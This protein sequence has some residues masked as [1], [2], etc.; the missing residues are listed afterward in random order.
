MNTH[1]EVEKWEREL[2]NLSLDDEMA[3]KVRHCEAFDFDEL[4]SF[5]RIQLSLA[6]Q[7]GIEFGKASMNPIADYERGREHGRNEAI[8]EVRRLVADG[9][10]AEGIPHAL[11]VRLVSPTKARE[12]KN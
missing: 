6:E 9:Y 4:K 11:E 12:I 2:L 10:T 8:E 3:K 5:I 1:N 7:R